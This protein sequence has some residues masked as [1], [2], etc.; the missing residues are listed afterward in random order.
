M[1]DSE[2]DVHPVVRPSVRVG[3]LVHGFDDPE[4]K[5]VVREIMREVREMEQQFNGVLVVAA[6]AIREL[7][8]ILGTGDTYATR[9]IVDNLKAFLADHSPPNAKEHTP[10]NE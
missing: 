4:H 9:E 7:E 5:A 3:R 10:S 8:R 6:D 1:S 2:I